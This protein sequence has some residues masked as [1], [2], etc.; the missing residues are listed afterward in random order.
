MMTEG[1]LFI[2]SPIISRGYLRP[3]YSAFTIAPNG[4]VTL[5]TG[6]IYQLV[7]EDRLVWKGRKEDFIQVRVHWNLHF[8]M[9]VAQSKNR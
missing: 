4:S 8:I 3:N 9:D 7:N 5:R 6:D 1:E 2:S